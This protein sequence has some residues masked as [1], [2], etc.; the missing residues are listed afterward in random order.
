MKNALVKSKLHGLKHSQSQKTINSQKVIVFGM[1]NVNLAL[2]IN[3]VYKVLNQ[4][5]IYGSGLNGVGIAHIGDREVT[6]VDLHQQLFQSNNVTEESKKSYLIVI[7]NT[8]NDLYGIP[9]ASVPTLMEIPQSTIR[10]LPEAYRNADV[11][12]FATHVAVIAEVEPPMTIFLLDVDQLLSN[13]SSR[14]QADNEISIQAE[15]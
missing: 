5:P 9:V 3:T 4:I 2:P 15:S 7:K 1:G 14:E 10:V 13:H 12:G 8:Q 6:V 11:F